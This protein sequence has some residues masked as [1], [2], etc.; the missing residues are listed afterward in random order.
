MLDERDIPEALLS[1]FILVRIYDMGYGEEEEVV[2]SEI[3]EY[4][5][6]NL[7]LR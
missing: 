3:A 7:L 1:G 2:R 5:R 6:E 4:L